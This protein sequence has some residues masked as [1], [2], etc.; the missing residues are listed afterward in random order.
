MY[1]RTEDGYEDLR[2][3]QVAGHADIRD[4]DEGAEGAVRP[5][6]LLGQ[7]SVADALRG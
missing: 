7:K 4:G 5:E 3:L 2:H 1:L 6:T